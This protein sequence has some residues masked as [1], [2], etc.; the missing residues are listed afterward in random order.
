MGMDFRIGAEFVSDTSAHT[1]RFSAIYFKEATV[2]NAITADNYTGNA[3]AGESF[4]ADS[5][6]YGI[7]TSITLTSGACIAYRI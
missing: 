6:I 2:I 3:L 4:P 1:G 7:F 5:T